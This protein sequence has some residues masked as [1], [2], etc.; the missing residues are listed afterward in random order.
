MTGI[1]GTVWCMRDNLT[2]I[3]WTAKAPLREAALSIA[4]PPLAQSWEGKIRRALV[5]DVPV[6]P[7]SLGVY[8]FGKE[9]ARTARLA[10]IADEL[11][12]ERLEVSMVC[13]IPCAG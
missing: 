2:E 7:T 8:G 4:D 3:A 1:L 5:R 11:G 6:P 13:L 10:L 12:E 9:L